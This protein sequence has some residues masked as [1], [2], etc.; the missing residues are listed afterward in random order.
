M[1]SPYAWGDMASVLPKAESG[2]STFSSD[3]H[4]SSRLSSACCKA[5]SR[6]LK[7]WIASAHAVTTKIKPAEQVSRSQL[8]EAGLTL[9]IVDVDFQNPRVLR[10]AD[11]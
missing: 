8:G 10:A 1:L 7:A 5:S 3:T 11:L 2:C 6:T 4:S 9:W